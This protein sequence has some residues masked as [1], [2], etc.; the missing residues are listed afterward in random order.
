MPQAGLALLR[1]L[2]YRGDLTGCGRSLG[3]NA[4]ARPGRVLADLMF[5]I[6]EDAT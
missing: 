4:K 3:A 2:S 5:V 6:A 1:H